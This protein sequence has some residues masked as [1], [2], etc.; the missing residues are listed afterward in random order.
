MG[1]A[2]RH[3][4]KLI[5][6]A[7]ALF[8][9]KGYAA[10]GLNEI[11]AASGAP[12]GSLYHYFPKGKEELGAEAVQQAG[13]AVTATLRQLH[14]TTETATA[15]LDAYCALLA[16]W[17]EKSGYRDGCP[18]ATTLLETLPQSERIGA[19]GRA[20]FDEWTAI[21]AA[22]HARDGMGPEA[23]RARAEFD[24]AAIEGALLLM[25]VRQSAAPLQN[26]A[27]ALSAL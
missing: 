5:G 10:T 11:L 21:I 13:A 3:R 23:A 18:I 7:I 2:A 24:L 19:A 15:F 26:V 17:V 1:A 22:V 4:E 16:G 12:K 9:R 8:R 14:D 20:A 6:S 27:R 25:R